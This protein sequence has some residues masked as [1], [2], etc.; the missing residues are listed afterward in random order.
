MFDLLATLDPQQRAV[1]VHSGSHLRVLAGAGTGKTT[2]LTGRAAHLITADRIP[3]ERILL[4]TFTR[5]AA[6]QMVGRT[7]ALIT[8]I[9]D[10][11]TPT[12]TRVMGGTFHSVAHT[13]LRQHAAALGLG[14]GF[15]VIDPSDA[16][17][18]IDVI[19]NDVVA[20][21]TLR[22]R[23]PRK[24]TLLDIYCRAVDTATPVSEV[25]TR[26]APWA[27][28]NCDEIIEICRR[29]VARKRS[30][31]VLDFDDLLLYWR[32]ALRHPTVGP[33]IAGHYDHVLV[34]E[35]QDVNALQVEILQLLAKH[36]PTL[37]VVGDDAQAIYSFRASSPDHILNFTQDFNGA[38]TLSLTTNYRSVPPI[39][40]LANAVAS[41]ASVGFSTR[42]EPC[43]EHLD[44]GTKPQLVRCADEDGQSDAVCERILELRETGIALREQAI[45]VRAAHHSDRLELELSR[46]AIPFVKYGGL[47]Y[48][49]A[50]HVKDLLAA[51]RIADNPRDEL[52]WFR[53]L[54]LLQGVGPAKARRAVDSLGFAAATDDQPMS[55]AD[56]RDRWP[57]AARDLPA[58]AATDGERLIAAL[59]PRDDEP[60]TVRAERIRACISP[61]IEANYDD[62]E[63]RLT[64]LEVLVQATASAARLS[65][66]AAEHALEPPSSTG[67]LAGVP[68]ID[69]DFVVIST[70]HSAKGLEWDCVH[71]IHAADGNFPS[72]M[73][74]N[75]SA[76]LEE[77]R[78][79]FYVA[80]TR[81]RRSLD[82]Y[83][84]LR[85]HV[86]R[87]A[88][89]D[90]H[91]WAQPSRFVTGAARA[92]LADVTH[93]RPADF[94]AIELPS[95]D[96][97]LSVDAQLDGLWT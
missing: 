65:E 14:D 24:S 10:T 70:V 93:V 86:N 77:E 4:L 15:G 53:V 39:L 23:L 9:H 40:D 91:I 17:D 69:E 95:I 36:G 42:L 60:L 87:H 92:H 80:A 55:L 35:Y 26:V 51:F 66:V 38:S 29:F 72:D 59:P 43:V 63:A 89:D 2:A 67:D 75:D 11:P 13:T 47:K 27:V 88:A 78:R 1:A 61:L 28:R 76:G 21:H 48:L 83:V 3:A 58:R 25:L 71:V 64:D 50:A 5:R 52:S 31:G 62:A 84:P 30:L 56:V 19:R 94:G 22:R 46:R 20:D 81:A 49:E 16:G 33:T 68:T 12:R 8:R 57:A 45:L 41:E 44:S 18:L 6:R 54:Q 34:D 85:F 79:L 97:A 96:A 37:T 73:A 32:E 7:S 90:R 82:I 74:L